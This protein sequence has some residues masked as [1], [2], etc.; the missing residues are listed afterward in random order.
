M[1][2]LKAD[3]TPISISP[4]YTDFADVFSKNLATN[5]SQL[6]VINIYSLT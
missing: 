3:K 5:L 2:L 4:K 6:I 1:V